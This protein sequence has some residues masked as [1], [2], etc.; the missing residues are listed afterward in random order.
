[1]RAVIQRV[2]QAKVVCEGVVTGECG[3]GLVILLGVHQDDTDSDA[4][5]VAERVPKLRI[6]N[7]SQGKMN[8]DLPSVLTE[9]AC[10]LLV[11][12]NFTVYGDV[13]SGRRPSF[14]QSAS[15][16]E[17]KRLYETFVD[18]LK[19]QGF[20]TATGIFGADMAVELVNDGPVTLV[21]D[22]RG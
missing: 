14:S 19:A 21:I 10:G 20:V 3:I 4:R 1:M 5:K 16:A 7:D 11:I 18:A 2:S 12:S 15:F 22:S 9:G 17:A 13:W 8:L 6:F